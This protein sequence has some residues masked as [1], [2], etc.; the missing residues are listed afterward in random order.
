[1]ANIYWAVTMCHGASN[2]I[3]TAITWDRF[4]CYP[5]F[6]AGLSGLSKVTQV[7]NGGDEIWTQAVQLESPCSEL[8][9]YAASPYKYYLHFTNGDT[10]PN[11]TE[12]IH[13]MARMWTRAG[14]LCSPWAYYPPH[15]A[16]M[17][18][19]VSEEWGS[20]KQTTEVLVIFGR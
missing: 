13:G 8:W 5:H 9:H 19:V 15:C 1:M 6:E 20:K 3:L 4:Y 16:A 14:P 17:A 7:V 11:I 10:G 12:L 18:R 2:L